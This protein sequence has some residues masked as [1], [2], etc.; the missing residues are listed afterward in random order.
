MRIV[1]DINHPCEVTGSGALYG[2]APAPGFRAELL[3][4]SPAWSAPEM[5]DEA[6]YIEGDAR[7]VRQALVDAIKVI[8]RTA[9][10]Y[11]AEGR[12]DPNWAETPKKA[13]A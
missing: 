11:V 8:D 12:L 6:I 7:H 5:S 3:I 13:G 1:H 10:A 2:H 9:Q 4:L